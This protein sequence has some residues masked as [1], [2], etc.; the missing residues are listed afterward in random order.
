MF[1]FGVCYYPEHWDESLW[2]DDF[3]RM[4]ALGMNTVRMGE[5]AWAV[6][7]PAE[8]Q[9]SFDLF[10]RAVALA[11]KHGL[12][13]IMGTPTYAPPAWVTHTY[14][15]T[16][17]WDF[18]R[19]PM[20]HGGRR[21]YNYTS[22]VFRKLSAQVV[23][24]L[25]EH[26][27]EN[28]YVIGWQV[29]NE[30]NCHMDAS[31]SPSDTAAFRAWCQEKY[32]TLAELNRAWGVRF[33]SQDY[34]DWAQVD[35]PHP[36]PAYPNPH[37]VLDAKRFYSDMVTR[38]CKLQY[39][40]LK[41][42]NPAWSITHNGIFNHIDN[43]KLAREALDF[44]SYDSYPCFGAEPRDWGMSLGK[45]RGMSPR[46]WVL[47]QQSG[48]GG[49]LDYLHR[50]PEPGQ[51][52]LWTYQSIA[53]GADGVLYFRWRTCTVGAEQLWHGL[54]DY[55]NVEN[56]RIAEARQVGEELGRFG[57]CIEHLRGK[58]QVALLY[59]F[60]NDM[61]DQIETYVGKQVRHCNKAVFDAATDRHLGVDV[62]DL[63]S[64]DLAGYKVVLFPHPTI[65]TEA[66][67]DKLEAYV[68]SGGTLIVGA[69]SGFKDELG[70]A[71]MAELPGLLRPICGV[72]VADFTMLK[73]PVGV[74][75]RGRHLQAL[76]FAEILRAEGAEVIATYTD[77][78][79]AGKPAAVRH[80]LGEGQAIYWG[81]YFTAETVGRLL[82]LTPNLKPYIDADSRVEV[83]RRGDLLFVLNHEPTD[84]HIYP[85]RTY[86]DLISGATIA[87]VA[88]VPGYGVMILEEAE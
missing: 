87:D 53:H 65:L 75:L 71:R 85:A 8:G 16:L 74:E 11:A 22:P 14:P 33:W 66:E 58:G 64:A 44:M 41:Q 83:V 19:R 25:A 56:R 60:A 1:R 78:Y 88:E 82:G 30:F 13:V 32:G 80:R 68:R 73:E 15:E 12:Q 21:H 10:D 27:K 54:N 40:I 70:H 45:V 72:A 26:Y 24:A 28:P 36:C 5:S 67:A 57:D 47:E 4:A 6:W 2:A 46:F 48:P 62:L 35:L 9:Y 49:Q 34:S 51:M 63:P 20:A 37:Q 84:R 79:F 43:P 17:A 31:Y 3:R 61:N 39:D 50:S 18:Q 77:H 38:Y 29:D 59:S 81:S 42:A 7:E 52:R 86:R 69:R 76:L 55:G 23:E